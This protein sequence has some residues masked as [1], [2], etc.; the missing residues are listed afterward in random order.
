MDCSRPPG[1][2][3]LVAT[4]A[5]RDARSRENIILHFD[6]MCPWKE[7]RAVISTLRPTDRSIL[8]PI[9]SFALQKRRNLF[10]LCR[11]STRR[12]C[13][14]ILIV[15]CGNGYCGNVS[16]NC[17][18]SLYCIT[19]CCTFY[20]NCANSVLRTIALFIVNS[21]ITKKQSII[22]EQLLSSF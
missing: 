9:L 7:E 10:P 22:C 8:L 12:L 16:G 2:R 20:R 4:R 6:D 15:R 13:V 1:A 18:F 19:N 17:T 5:R 21:P 11:R 14:G 3:S